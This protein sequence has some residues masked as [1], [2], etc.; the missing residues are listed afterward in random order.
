MP[1]HEMKN[2][3]FTVL[4]ACLSAE[5][6]YRGA[7]LR[8]Q[9]MNKYRRVCLT[10]LLATGMASPAYADIYAFSDESG[11]LFLS[12]V[13]ED[14]RYKLL[15]ASPD[16]PAT[17][18]RIVPVASAKPAPYFHQ[19]MPFGP[20]VEETARLN[21]VD[22]ALLHAVITA[23][24]GY[25]PRALSRAGASGL[26]QLMP[27]TARRYGVAD[28]YDPAQNVRGGARYLKDLL[29]LFN[30]D[31]RLTLAAYN[32]GENAVVQYGNKIPPYRETTKYVNKVMEL[33]DQYRITF[34]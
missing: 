19:G 6:Y 21:L 25:N 9:E 13:Q 16:A 33:Y 29:H 12:N 15:V 11:A 10:M 27:A 18:N 22:A 31:L 4:P 24:S 26:M 20:L 1:P 32:A 7:A 3:V 14:S 30:N 5:E 2:T 8:D 17:H 28:I 23:E 34:P